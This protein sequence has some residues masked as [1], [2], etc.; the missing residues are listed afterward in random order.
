[1]KRRKI[2]RG[3]LEM[4]R[5]LLQGVADTQGIKKTLLI[6]KSGMNSTG[7]AKYLGILIDCH[8]FEIRDEGYY[9]TPTGQKLLDRLTE[10]EKLL[11]ADEFKKL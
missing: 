3:E 8:A 9:L 10:C 4:E 7:G 6:G 5:L 2:Y 1:M 11:G